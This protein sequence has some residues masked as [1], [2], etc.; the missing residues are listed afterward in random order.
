M[1]TWKVWHEV[2]QGSGDF[3]AHPSE[4]DQET[5]VLAW[6]EDNAMAHTD[7]TEYWNDQRTSS[8]G[9]CWALSYVS[10]D[11]FTATP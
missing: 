7:S 2:P 10:G 8:Q 3:M 5:V 6:Y 4:E 11:F 9:C 1:A